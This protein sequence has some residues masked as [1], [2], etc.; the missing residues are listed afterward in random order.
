MAYV[1]GDI[2]RLIVAS[3]FLSS[4][5]AYLIAE[6]IDRYKYET[7]FTNKYKCLT[8]PLLC[9]LLELELQDGNLSVPDTESFLRY[10]SA[11]L[12]YLPALLLSFPVHRLSLAVRLL[13]LPEILRSAYL[14]VFRFPFV[15]KFSNLKTSNE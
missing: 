12:R 9:H 5:Q 4:A 3:V 7:K 8:A 2:C 10:L 11:L 14:R 13:Y 1:S 15:L 6:A